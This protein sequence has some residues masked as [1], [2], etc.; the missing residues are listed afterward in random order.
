MAA[1]LAVLFGL[2]GAIVYGAADFFGGLAS[3]RIGALRAAG[4]AALAGLGILLAAFSLVGGRWSPD[5]ILF[6][7]LSGVAGA[8]ALSLLYAC[9]ALGPMSVLSPITA[10][11][12]AVVPMTWGLLHGERVG[13]FGSIGLVAAIVAILLVAFVPERTSVRATPRAVLMAVGSGTMIGVFLVLIDAT[14]PDSGVVPLLVN[15]V[16]NAT[17]MFTAIALLPRRGGR[18]E[19]R[20]ARRGIRLAL[21]CGALDGTANALILA[22]VRTGDLTVVSVLTALYPAGTIALAAFVL[23]ERIS[24]VQ[25]A[26]LLLALVAATLLALG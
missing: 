26:G 17:L 22:G 21:L 20:D 5:A 7:A 11:V 19:T 14:P 13:L 3:R 15:R 12:A 10:L 18:P 2:S 4:L 6:G 1:L 8:L 23:R 16:V 9:L 25:S 24:P